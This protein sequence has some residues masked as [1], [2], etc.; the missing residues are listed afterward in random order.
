MGVGWIAREKADT[1]VSIHRLKRASFFTVKL[2]QATIRE[3]RTVSGYSSTTISFAALKILTLILSTFRYRFDF[4]SGERLK[5]L[6]ANIFRNKW[7]HA[8]SGRPRNFHNFEGTCTILLVNTF[9]KKRRQTLRLEKCLLSDIGG[10]FPIRHWQ[11]KLASTC[12]MHARK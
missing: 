4:I 12:I 2:K 10:T 5:M 9:F 1:G 3:Q 6:F 7:M 8:A 11:C